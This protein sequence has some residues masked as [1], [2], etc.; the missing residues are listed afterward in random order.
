[1]GFFKRGEIVTKGDSPKRWC[2]DRLEER[3]RRGEPYILATLS[4]ED[5]REAFAD[6]DELTKVGG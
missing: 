6:T 5:G 1:M 3:D 2:V 4:D